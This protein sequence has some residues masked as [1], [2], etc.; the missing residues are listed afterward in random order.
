MLCYALR[1]L[2]KVVCGS[3]VIGCSHLKRTLPLLFLI[4]TRP[5]RSNTLNDFCPITS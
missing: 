4:S 3:F 1:L 2:F 5:S